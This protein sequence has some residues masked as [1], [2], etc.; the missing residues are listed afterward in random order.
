MRA[1]WELLSRL[2]LQG[3]GLPILMYH[4]IRSTGADPVTV[5]WDDFRRQMDFL[6][7]HHFRFLTL[8]DLSEMIK[9]QSIPQEPAVLITFDDGD[10]ETIERLVPYLRE[11][12]LRASMFLPVFYIGKT[13]SWDGGG[14]PL[15]SWEELKSY[16]AQGLEWGLHSFRHENYEL[17]TAAMIKKDLLNC[18][19]ELETRHI[20]FVKAL[21]YPF[22]AFHRKGVAR[23]EMVKTLQELGIELAFRIGNRKNKTPWENPYFLQRLDI[24][25]QRP[26]SYFKAQLR[27]GKIL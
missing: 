20:P 5:T 23:E 24:Q 16:S 21:A 17:M 25:G 2:P 18:F 4:K 7:L 26:L 1:W 22:G 14:E 27:F 9:G 10:A 15:I 12:H 11:H 19:I 8:H 3:P 6:S 13:N